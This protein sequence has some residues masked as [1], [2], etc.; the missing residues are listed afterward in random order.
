MKEKA[1]SAELL[2]EREQEIL[3][4]LAAGS[5]DQQIADKLF[6]SLNTVKW[7]N[8]QIYSKLGVGSRTQAIACVKDFGL[9]GRSN[10]T[11]IETLPVPRYHLPT[12]THLFIGRSQGMAEVKQLLH[13]SRLL[14]LTGT[15]GI[16]KTQLALR[17]GAEVA[18][19][20]ADG[21]C[22]VDL[23]PLYNVSFA[24]AATLPV[25]G[26]TAL[27][28]LRQGGSLLGQRVLITGAA[29]GVGCFAVQ[30]A[31][32]AGAEVTG[33]V[34]N[35]DR[36]SGLSELGASAIV[37]NVH[38][39]EGLFDLILE[40]V[41]GSSLSGAISKVAPG[42]TIVMF[43]NSSRE[44]TPISFSNFA[45]HAFARLLPF[46]VYLSGTSASMGEDLAKLVSM[47]ASGKLKPEIGLEDSWHN[48]YKAAAALR[49]RKFKGKA[50]FHIP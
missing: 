30:L 2:N 43:G 49:D 40:S 46:F 42:G 36:A 39:A 47:V 29:G 13:V 19:S 17:V 21:I 4:H 35:S 15:G 37:S 7:Y 26:V 38:E 48:V 45:G 3:K 24:S 8:R 5:S 18:G 1:A 14:T 22:F 25:A 9:T 33:V 20:F 41:G 23:A 50:V 11:A 16:G 12:H 10:N 28:T 31:A 27:R 32:L 44:E 6:L 34:S